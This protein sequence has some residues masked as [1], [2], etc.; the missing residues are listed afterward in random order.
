MTSE[1]DTRPIAMVIK[2]TSSMSLGQK[3]K[4]SQSSTESPSTATGDSELNDTRTAA[5]GFQASLNNLSAR[6]FSQE[7][8]TSPSS[9]HRHRPPH[10]E[11]TIAQ[12]LRQDNDIGNA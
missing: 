10:Q 3:S 4:R 5:A 1:Y 7:R 8:S 9:A 11:A 6:V 12:F 2:E